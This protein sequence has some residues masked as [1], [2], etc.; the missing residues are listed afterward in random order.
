M[1][2]RKVVQ[3]HDPMPPV[4][5]VPSSN[6]RM[7]QGRHSLSM[8]YSIPSN[9]MGD[10]PAGLTFQEENESVK[11]IF[12][13]PFRGFTNTPSENGSLNSEQ[14]ENLLTKY[15]TIQ[16]PLQKVLRS[17]QMLATAATINF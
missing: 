15:S 7:D 1:I 3:D 2:M 14:R 10:W 12:R 9:E 4:Q 6:S 13:S 17:S 16:K 11:D 5:V 8:M